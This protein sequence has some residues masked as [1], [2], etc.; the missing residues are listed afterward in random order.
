[1]DK[2]EAINLI[3]DELGTH[4]VSSPTNSHPDVKTALIHIERETKTLLTRGYWFN[5]RKAVTIPSES[6]GYI[7]LPTDVLLATATDIMSRAMYAKRGRYM[8]DIQNNTR[9]IKGGMVLDMFVELDFDNLPINAQNTIAYAAAARTVS[10]KLSDT[11]KAN[12]LAAIAGAY[13]AELATDEL[14]V[15]TPNRYQPDRIASKIRRM[16]GRR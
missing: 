16:R 1:M 13:E 5:T 12:G 2:L 4:Q 15:T 8:W 7:V 10:S 3:L 9:I 14:R 6:N 11:V